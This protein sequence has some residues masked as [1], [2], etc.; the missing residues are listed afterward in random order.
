MGTDRQPYR[1]HKT[2]KIATLS[3]DDGGWQDIAVAGILSSWGVRATF[4]LPICRLT[5]Q[6]YG[7]PVVKLPAFYKRHEIGAHSVSHQPLTSLSKDGQQAEIGVSKKNLQELF[8]APVDCFAY[9]SGIY[10]DISIAMVE[11]LGFKW[12]RTANQNIEEAAQPKD[13]WAIPVSLTLGHGRVSDL[14]GAVAEGKNLHLHAHGHEIQRN[15]WITY[16]YDALALL[17]EGGYEIIPNS[18]YFEKA[19]A[20]G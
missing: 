11:L 15:E 13:R 3:F 1:I 17:S 10:D 6:L 12:G 8:Q 14:K 4:Y 9:P 2:L 7:L 16:L 18:E 20:N 5:P 19:M